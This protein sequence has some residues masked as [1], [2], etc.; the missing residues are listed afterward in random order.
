MWL[1]KLLVPLAR[2]RIAGVIALCVYLLR[3]WL[4][5]SNFGPT[6]SAYFNYLADAFLHQQLYLRLPTSNIIDLVDYAGKLYF[7]WPPFPAIL[8]LPLIAIFGAGT[9]DVIYTPI[10]GAVSIA[11][12]AKFLG[13]LDQT[14]IAPLSPERRGIMVA[15]T[16]FGTFLLILAPAGGAWYTAQIIGWGC[17]LLAAIAALSRSDKLGYLLVG[18]ALACATL[19][20]IGLVFNGVWLAYYLLHRDRQRPLRQTVAAACY[21]LVPVIVAVLLLGCYNAARFGNPLESGLAWQIVAPSAQADLTR[22]GQFNLHYLPKNLYYQ[23]G[24]YTLFDEDR[25]L[26]GG[27]FWMTPVLIGALYAIWRERRDLFVWTLVGSCALIYIPIGLLIGSGGITFGPRYLLDM[28][29]PLL[30]L[31]ARGIRE[32]RRDALLVLMIV[33]CVTYGLGSYFWLVTIVW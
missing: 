15:S 2:P 13:L 16:A 4:T 3:S 8:L 27:L 11:L 17:V 30:L 20:R 9:S 29:V 14:G 21:G 12:L 5:G 1:L 24:G 10:L 25:W 33:S 26:G 7:Y 22:Y 28:F 31:T 32:W 23:F 19:T 18:L 6:Q